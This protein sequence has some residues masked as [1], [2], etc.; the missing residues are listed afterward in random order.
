MWHMEHF[1]WLSPERR[2]E[3]TTLA[4]RYG[5]PV[6]RR[7]T[8]P[9][10]RP[11]LL[12]MVG[13]RDAEVCM[14][15]QRPDG[16]FITMTKAFYPPGIFRLPT[17][18]VE[19]GETIEA[20]LRREVDEETGLEIII[21]RLLAVTGYFTEGAP[22]FI[23]FTFLVREVGGTLAAKDLAERVA[24]YGSLRVADLPA[25]IAQLEAITSDSRTDQSIVSNAW[26]FLR[27]D[28]HRGVWEALG[29]R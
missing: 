7:V 19:A 10:M 18:G 28:E 4:A 29:R 12:D 24:A 16:S 14:V 27:A 21:E 25:H 13:K 26:A 6:A 8:D 20:A 17:G 5:A 1:G 9:R 22:V 3:I 2:A 11:F 23:C 15:I